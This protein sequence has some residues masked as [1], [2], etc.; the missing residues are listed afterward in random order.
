MTSANTY[1][2]ISRTHLK[3]FSAELIGTMFILLFGNGVCAMNSLFNLGG[4][5]N[6]TFGWGLGVFLGIIVSNRISGAHL[7]PAITIAL[8]VT[9]RFPIRKAPHYICGQMLGGFIG[10]ALVYYFYQA[11]FAIIDP[12]LSSSAGIFSTFPA[13]S[14]F[15]PSLMAEVIATA[16]LMFGILAIVEHFTL[17]KA[18]FLSPFAVSSLV[19]AIGMSFGGMH[20]YAMNP[21]RDFSPR[22]F[23]AI[24]GFANNGLTD[25]SYIWIVPVIGPIFGAILG[26][27][28]YNILKGDNK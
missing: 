21:A 2:K 10:A 22:L 8:I 17:D 24:M 5:T 27:V 6:I 16:I 23:T 7:N 1:I 9:K 11:K 4:Y 18:G 13:V 12:T 20:G 3:E 19:V 26:A 15:M 14:A 25:G 28:L